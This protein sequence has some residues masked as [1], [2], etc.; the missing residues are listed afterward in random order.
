MDVNQYKLRIQEILRASDPSI[1]SAKKIRQQLETEYKIS[2][3]PVKKEL[4]ALVMDMFYGLEEEL[5]QNKDVDD[6]YDNDLD[7]DN[8]NDLDGDNDNDLDGDNDDNG[9]E[10][11]PGCDL[12]S[13]DMA[14]AETTV[15]A[16]QTSGS[17]Q[18]FQLALPPTTFAPQALHPPARPSASAPASSTP[19]RPKK[20]KDTISGSDS[21][22]SSTEDSRPRA[23]KARTGTAASKATGSKTK[24]K[25]ARADLDA[26]MARKL[27]SEVN[28]LR[29]TRGEARG[30]EIVFKKKKKA[31]DE[32]E[33]EKPKKVT[34][35]NKP[36][37]LSP[38]L[39]EILGESEVSLE[40][41]G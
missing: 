5:N 15:P 12:M 8:D 27:H 36:L 4:D 21:D 10:N 26:E 32:T 20:S 18:H 35:F 33:T 16:A 13:F 9:P 28:G 2:L 7:G 29:T 17:T 23:K 6:P 39:A 22:L 41:P 25:K 30:G 40:G 24:G 14:V 37:M 19:K 1:V 34:G 38:A 3:Q 31:G 11:V